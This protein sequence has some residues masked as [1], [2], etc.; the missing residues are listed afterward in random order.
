MLLDGPYK[1]NIRRIPVRFILN[2]DI[3][4]ESDLSSN[5]EN[6]IYETVNDSKTSD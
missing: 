4:E 1:R 5:S 6:E 2:P 3:C